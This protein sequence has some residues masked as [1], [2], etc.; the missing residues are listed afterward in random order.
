MLTLP[1]M[2]SGKSAAENV[3][4]PV[5]VVQPLVHRPIEHKNSAPDRATMRIS[6]KRNPLI[7]KT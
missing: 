1:P 4:K 2:S 5:R 6:R 3:E 7:V